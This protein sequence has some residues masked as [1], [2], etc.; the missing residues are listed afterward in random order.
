MLLGNNFCRIRKCKQSSA[1]E[2]CSKQKK[3]SVLF[4]I[5]KKKLHWCKIINLYMPLVLTFTLC[6][7]AEK[8]FKNRRGCL[9]SRQPLLIF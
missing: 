5:I 6:N 7:N 3:K 4:D 1:I 8:V 9:K 2:Y